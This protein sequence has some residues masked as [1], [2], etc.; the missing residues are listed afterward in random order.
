MFKKKRLT[1]EE[2]VTTWQLAETLGAFCESTGMNRRAASV[3]A[4]FYRKRGVNLKRFPRGPLG[5]K[6]LNIELLNQLISAATE[7]VVI[8]DESGPAGT[9]WSESPFC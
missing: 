6:C 5:R 4:T 9:I 3:R 1:P 8:T 2:F 7:E